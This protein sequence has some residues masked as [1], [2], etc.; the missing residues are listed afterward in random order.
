MKNF[1]AIISI[2]SV[3]LLLVTGLIIDNRKNFNSIEGDTPENLAT[4]LSL[5]NNV[6]KQALRDL[7]EILDYPLDR[8]TG[9]PRIELV[10]LPEAY[11]DIQDDKHRKAL[12]LR[13]LLPLVL[14][15]NEELE[16][17]RNRM[18]F[19]LKKIE[20][21]RD[22]NDEQIAEIRALARKY[23]I[24]GDPSTNRKTREMLRKR[25]DIVPPSL[26]LA[27]AANESGW[28][29][30]RF[31]MEASNLFGI[32]TYNKNVGVIPAK[33]DSG[34]NHLIRKFDSLRDSVRVY[35]HTLNTHSAY[36]ELR[37]IRNRM[38]ESRTNLNGIAIAEGLE[39]Y[40]ALGKQYVRLIQKIIA[41][42][43]LESLNSIRLQTA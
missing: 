21:E 40:S 3:G 29:N 1:L 31:A 15:E 26:A 43:D 27:Q 7:V 14:L 33:R 32:W 28:G 16:K 12:F 2:L 38:T 23:G 36:T 25:V 9:I 6:K 22:L 18:N 37:E 42:N 24:K 10:H 19:L 5:P 20:M 13:L 11:T 39:K 4:L 8:R 34:K 30:S 17:V 35:M 41:I